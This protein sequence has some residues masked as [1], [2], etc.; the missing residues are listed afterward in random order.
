MGNWI[1]SYAAILG[2]EH[3]IQMS[4]HRFPPKI[5]IDIFG[6]TQV[7][8]VCNAMWFSVLFTNQLLN[9]RLKPQ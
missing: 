8:D 2:W 4:Y 7:L 5:V 1:K 6:L 9:E 3:R